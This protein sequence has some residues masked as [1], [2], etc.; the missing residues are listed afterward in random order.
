MH[1]H[2]EELTAASPLFD[3]LQGRSAR[4]GGLAAAAVLGSE[5]FDTSAWTRRRF[6]EHLAVTATRLDAAPSRHWTMDLARTAPGWRPVIPCH[7]W[8]TRRSRRN[9]SSRFRR[10]ARTVLY[11]NSPRPDANRSFPVFSRELLGAGFELYADDGSI[12]IERLR[13][14]RERQLRYGQAIAGRTATG[15]SVTCGFRRMTSL[16]ASFKIPLISRLWPVHLVPARPYW[17]C[18]VRR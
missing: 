12:D 7:I 8:A 6:G 9:S 5:R 16:R 3:L 18:S 15:R 1:G 10:R 4:S 14:Q 13:G 2:L 17:H 11:T